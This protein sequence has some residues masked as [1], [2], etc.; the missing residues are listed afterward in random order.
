MRYHLDTFERVIF[1]VL[2]RR[3]KLRVA[4]H[5]SLVYH[6]A[7]Y[8][9]IEYGSPRSIVHRGRVHGTEYRS[10]LAGLVLKLRKLLRIYVVLVMSITDHELLLMLYHSRQSTFSGGTRSCWCSHYITATSKR[11]TCLPLSQ[12]MLIV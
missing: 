4:G 3:N 8:P 10:F 2:K 11:L 9:T 7:K 1:R 6:G 5:R 12:H